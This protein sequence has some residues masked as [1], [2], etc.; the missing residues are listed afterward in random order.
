MAA[1]DHGGDARGGDL[2]DGAGIG[3]QRRNGIGVRGIGGKARHCL[4]QR[5]AAA[6]AGVGQRRAGDI[7]HL[8]RPA[9]LCDAGSHGAGPGN[10]VA[11][12]RRAAVAARIGECEGKIGIGFFGSLQFVRKWRAILVKR[13]AA[14]IAVEHHVDAQRLGL[15]GLSRAGDAV[16]FF[17][18]GQEQVNVAARFE[19]GGVQP[20]QRGHH[21][22]D[23]E[24]VVL[25]AA[26]KDIAAVVHGLERITRPISRIGL[27]HIQMAGQRHR[28][29]LG[30]AG[31]APDEMEGGSVGHLLNIDRA[32][33]ETR[34]HQ[35]VAV[36]SRQRRRLAATF[37]AGNVHTGHQQR[38][39][40]SRIAGCREGRGAEQGGSHQ[41][42]SMFHG[43]TLP[44]GAPLSKRNT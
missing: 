43:A 32:G 18:A 33:V 1:G 11:G 8:R 41:S 21:H 4:A 42:K 19:S 39:C 2:P 9:V 34:L 22:R 17:V 31:G 10:G 5:V 37:H 23:V 38:L 36:Q 25:H 24:L 7:V 6:A 44:A 3:A 12:A 27:H 28:R 26:A 16:G 30:L 13:A 15:P 14:S 35:P 40:R 20:G 29:G